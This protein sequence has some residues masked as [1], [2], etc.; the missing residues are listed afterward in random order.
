MTINNTGGPCC[1]HS[2]IQFGLTP[3]SLEEVMRIWNGPTYKNLRLNKCSNCPNQKYNNHHDILGIGENIPL[4]SIN[5]TQETI[6][7]FNTVNKE[8]QYGMVTLKHPPIELYVAHSEICNLSCKMCP[9]DRRATKLFPVENI[10]NVVHEIGWEKLDRFGFIGGESFVSPDGKD[11]LKL[12]SEEDTKGTC[13]YL[14]TNGT[15]IPE[16]LET[17]EKIDNLF[18]TVRVDGMKETYESIRHFS[19]DKLYSNLKVLSETAKLHPN[20]RLNINS[21][22]MKSTYKQVEDL[23]KMASDLDMSIF[24]SHIGGGVTNESMFSIP[25][26]VDKQEVIAT[27][28][29]AIETAS[30]LNAN[31]ANNSLEVTI[32]RLTHGW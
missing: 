31:K 17:L 26:I 32:D 24:F 30:I 20:W 15:L 5:K 11:L 16:N 10:I 28:T 4:F 21:I 3:K 14:T 27:I 19:W 7:Y 2:N 6:E 22:I 12:V 8:Y 23:I 25:N 1:Y 9:R 13:I 29:K 18:I